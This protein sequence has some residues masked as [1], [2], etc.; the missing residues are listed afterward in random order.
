MQGLIGTINSPAPLEIA[1]TDHFVRRAKQLQK[2]EVCLK[3]D[4]QA[5]TEVM[6]P[7]HE[8]GSTDNQGIGGNGRENESSGVLVEKDECRTLRDE[9]ATLALTTETLET[10]GGPS[11]E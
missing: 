10:V 2:E 3:S 9:K 7:D 4:F 11:V 8:S 1:D 6:D 5:A